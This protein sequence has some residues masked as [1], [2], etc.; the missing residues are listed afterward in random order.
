MKLAMVAAT[1][2]APNISPPMNTSPA[3]P[4]VDVLEAAE[5]TRRVED[6]PA[7]DATNALLQNRAGGHHPA[8]GAESRPEI[9]DINFGNT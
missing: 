8:A 7:A 3:S 4:A 6:T 9:L 1:S 5:A 2:A